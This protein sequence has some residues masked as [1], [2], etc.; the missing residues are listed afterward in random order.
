MCGNESEC[1]EVAVREGRVWTR[2]SKAPARSPL[3]FT[4]SVWAHF[5]QAVA[6]GE[7]SGL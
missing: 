1:V 5:L 2:D 6:Q 4:H 3:P 7:L